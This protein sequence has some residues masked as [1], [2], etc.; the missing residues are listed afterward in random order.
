MPAFNKISA[1]II[2]SI[3]LFFCGSGAYAERIRLTGPTFFYVSPTGNDDADGLTANTPWH[4]LQHAYNTVKNN[5]DLAGFPVTIHLADGTY[6]DNVVFCDG[7]IVGQVANVIFQG[8]P[9]HPENVVL[10]AKSNNIFEVMNTR[11]H[12]DGMTLSGTGSTVGLL[13]YFGARVTFTNLIFGPMGTGIHLSAYGGI[14][15]AQS[16]YRITGGAGYH[17]LSNTPGS[18]VHID[19]RTITI[20]NSPAFSAAF[21]VAENLA[22]ISAY[23]NSFPG[24][25]ATGT[26]YIVNM[27]SII[28]TSGGVNYFPGDKAGAA[29]TGGQ[30]AGN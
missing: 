7:Y 16:N 11:V 14:I 2:C 26:R 4:T 9:E 27:N 15:M 29:G 10:F 28:Q 8:N 24:T 6:K 20:S 1:I 21:A 25:A 12:V 13:S 30:Y 18:R 17:I 5:Y 3:A 19:N 23:G 22:M